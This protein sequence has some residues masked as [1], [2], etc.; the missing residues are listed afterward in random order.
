M[1]WK[2]FKRPTI[3]QP[4]LIVLDLGLPTLNG[5]EEPPAGSARSLPQSKILFVSQESSPDDRGRGS[6]SWGQRAT[7]VKAYAGSELLPAAVEVVHDR[8]G[9]RF[10]SSRSIGSCSVAQAKRRAPIL[11]LMRSIVRPRAEGDPK[12]FHH[13]GT[14]EAGRKAHTSAHILTD[15]IPNI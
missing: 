5:I 9:K 8:Q 7:S 2:Q 3:L 12:Q 4:D 13:R 6:E 11:C 14:S 1:G 15:S 10:I